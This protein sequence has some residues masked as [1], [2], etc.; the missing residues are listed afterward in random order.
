VS[1]TVGEGE[2]AMLPGRNGM[3]KTTTIRMMGVISAPAAGPPS[4]ARS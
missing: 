2:V 3:G 4:M 1:L